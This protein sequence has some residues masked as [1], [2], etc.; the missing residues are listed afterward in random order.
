VGGPL[1]IRGTVAID[2]VTIAAGQGTYAGLGLN[3]VL[4][5]FKD[6]TVVHINLPTNVNLHTTGPI[7]CSVRLDA[8]PSLNSSTYRTLYD[9]Y[10]SQ[11]DLTIVQG[12]WLDIWAH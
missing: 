10:A 7:T 12:S 1:W 5:Q 3:P 8:T 11:M 9:Y 4:G 2:V 6:T